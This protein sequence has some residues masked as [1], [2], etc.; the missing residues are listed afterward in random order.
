MH[1]GVYELSHFHS[2]LLDREEVTK[3]YALY[4]C[5]NVENYG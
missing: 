2:M 1:A 4:A 5:E 3:E